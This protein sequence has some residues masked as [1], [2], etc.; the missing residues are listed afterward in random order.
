MS[1]F[2]RIFMTYLMV[3]SLMWGSVLPL[4]QAE[5]T[6]VYYPSLGVV[7]VNSLEIQ[8][9]S[10]AFS[11]D[12]KTLIASF[13]TPVTA[14]VKD[15]KANVRVFYN[16]ESEGEKTITASKVSLANDRMLIAFASAVRIQEAVQISI[17]ENTL[18]NVYGVVLESLIDNSAIYAQPDWE[19]PRI[20]TLS[21]PDPNDDSYREIND[22]KV[23]SDNR[24]ISVRFHEAIKKVPADLRSAIM[25]ADKDDK[26]LSPQVIRSAS[27]SKDRVNMVLT[28]SL[29]ALG[30]EK[31]QF[32]AAA[33]EDQAGNRNETIE[34]SF[35]SEGLGDYEP[36]GVAVFNGKEDVK[37]LSDRQ[38]ILIRFNEPIFV[39]NPALF[40]AEISYIDEYGSTQLPQPPA[41][42][43]YSVKNDILTLKLDRPIARWGIIVIGL[44]PQAFRDLAGNAYPVDC[45]C[46]WS[47]NFADSESP[48]LMTSYRSNDQKTIIYEFNEPIMKV[49]AVTDLKSRIQLLLDQEQNTTQD[50]ASTDRIT[51]QHNKLMVTFNSVKR[52][53][54]L[55]FSGAVLEDLFGNTYQAGEFNVLGFPP[56]DDAGPDR[57]K[58]TYT[59][60]DTVRITFNKSLAKL[61]KDINAKI[62][63]SFTDYKHPE[64]GSIAFNAQPLQPGDKVT[65]INRN[66]LQI[67]FATPFR[68][69]T[70]GFNGGNL[71]FVIESGAVRDLAGFP[72]ATLYFQYGKLIEGEPNEE[73]ALNL[74]DIHAPGTNTMNIKNGNRLVEILFDEHIFPTSK[75]NLRSKISLRDPGAGF[76]GESMAGPGEPLPTSTKVSIAG[77]KLIIEFA[78]PLPADTQKELLLEP[79]ALRDALGNRFGFDDN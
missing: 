17:A 66:T 14:N 61:P 2:I 26:P 65:L 33:V 29:S 3:M 23:S 49:P 18:K 50:L 51:I 73:Q 69:S 67:K 59:R 62:K 74:F 20:A 54:G 8:L 70:P 4:S 25:V 22:I 57:K 31:L 56:V 75:G 16:S 44:A 36:P 24:S 45:S 58:I 63:F 79:G 11:P 5:G 47:V 48:E 71:F 78:A 38:T 7:Q 72:N 6:E 52:I 37:V 34:Y 30:V 1:M 28:K 19:K 27:V 32:A 35:K 12:Q 10:L 68:A 39:T 9:E 42:K 40:H 53:D 77:K 64:Y 15:L 43:K 13:N 55:I 41:V 46:G 60:N 76:S 21:V